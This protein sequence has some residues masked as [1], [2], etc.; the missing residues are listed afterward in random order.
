MVRASAKNYRNVIITVNPQSYDEVLAALNDANG[1]EGVSMEMRK[2]LAL[3]AFQ[4]RCNP[5]GKQ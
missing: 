3:E 2:E 5:L 4:L 1:A